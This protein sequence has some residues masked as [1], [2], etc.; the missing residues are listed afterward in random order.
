MQHYTVHAYVQY[1]YMCTAYYGDRI[2]QH[3][4]WMVCLCLLSVRSECSLLHAIGLGCWYSI[5]VHCLSV[6]ERSILNDSLVQ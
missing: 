6:N 1:I 2:S 5:Y 4:T 3:A